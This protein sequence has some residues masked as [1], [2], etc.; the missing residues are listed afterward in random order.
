MQ[1]NQYDKRLKRI[2]NSE[3]SGGQEIVDVLKEFRQEDIKL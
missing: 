2:L 1:E 3:Y